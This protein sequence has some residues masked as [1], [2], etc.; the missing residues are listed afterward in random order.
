M[1]LQIG[2]THGLTKTSGERVPYVPPVGDSDK[3]EIV[4]LRN[5]VLDCSVYAIAAYH[6]LGLHRWRPAQ[7]KQLEE[8]IQPPTGDLFAAASQDDEAAQVESITQAVRPRSKGS[9]RR[10]RRRGGFVSSALGGM[11]GG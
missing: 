5:E 2:L 6:Y 3:I 8:K 1:H 4:G 11:H 9:A 7:W 10:P